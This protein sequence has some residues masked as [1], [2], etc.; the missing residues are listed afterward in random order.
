L[1]ATFFR[2]FLLRI[3]IWQDK[4]KDFFFSEFFFSSDQALRAKDSLSARYY[5]TRPLRVDWAPIT[6]FEDVHST[7]LFVDRVRPSAVYA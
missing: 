5:K 7:L 1:Y 3:P 4:L 2:V 6:R